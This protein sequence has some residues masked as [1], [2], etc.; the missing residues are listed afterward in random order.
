MLEL[1]ALKKSYFYIISEFLIY[2]IPVAIIIG[3]S[4]LNLLNLIIVINFVIIIIKNKNILIYYK[5]I[6]Q[7]FFL[8]SIF[9]FINILL[10]EDKSRSLVSFIGFFGHYIIM[11]S[12]ILCI[13]VNF[14]FRKNFSKIIF[15][16]LIFVGIDTLYQYLSGSDIF[17]H[18]ISY[19]HG[20]RLSGP[21]GDE[22]V[23][24]SFISK[25]FFISI[26]FIENK[27]LKYLK[28]F[29]VFSFFL[30]VILS[31][32]RAASLMFLFSIIIYFVLNDEFSI[33][34][35]L[36]KF[37][38][39]IVIIFIF[40]SFNNQLKDHFIKRTFD[41]IGITQNNT[42]IHN[43]FWDS[44]WG[45]HFLTSIEIYKDYPI[46]GSGLRTFRI[47]CSDPKYNN[48]DSIEYEV[49][50]N[51][52]PHNIYLEILSETGTVGFIIFISFII[53]ITFKF[54]LIIIRKTNLNNEE[55][56]LFITFFLLFNPLQTT[57]A[58]FS[59]WNGMFYWF[60]LPLIINL[61]IRTNQE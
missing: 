60:L 50:C 48:I 13:D 55:L 42:K 38:T 44:Q 29:L 9:F 32:E 22:Y 1:K 45:A 52:H 36:A 58:F 3:N 23:V 40:F 19:G 25:L 56:C 35:K 51:T 6:I 24:G 49:R 27:K 54:I 7:I 31:N 37:S 39:L 47:V 14:S 59:T 5:K 20:K 57:G 33:K 4:V 21:F 16:V 10:S 61:F 11:T 34:E 18:E 30:I 46:I 53:F 17:G 41:Q 2:F 26:L 15:L 28:L 12:I 8:I 43:N